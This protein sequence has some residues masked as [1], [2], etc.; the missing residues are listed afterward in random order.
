MRV[1]MLLWRH[2]LCIIAYDKQMTLYFSQIVASVLYIRG[3]SFD[4]RLTNSLFEDL[5]LKKNQKLRN[6]S[7][8]FL[9]S[10]KK[11]I[12]LKFDKTNPLIS[13][14]PRKV[15]ALFITYIF[16]VKNTLRPLF[17]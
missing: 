2:T 3:H 5:R 17:S 12:R 6:S 16:I 10:W 4:I 9:D 8:H 1:L 14:Q 11:E 13:S 15:F 7:N